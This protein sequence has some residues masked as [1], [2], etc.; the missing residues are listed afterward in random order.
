MTKKIITS[1]GLDLSLTGTGIVLLEGGDIKLQRLI[2]SKPGGDKPVNELIRIRTIVEEIEMI[3][4]EN[5]PTV[6]VIEGMAFMARNTTALVQLAALN[7]MTRSLL[8]DYKIPFVICAPTS[9][10]KFITGKGNS[11]KDV[12]LIETFKRYDKTILNDNEND[13]FGLAKIGE[14]LLSKDTNKLPIF[15]Q[16]VLK[17]ITKQL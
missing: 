2:K 8:Y 15:Q 11:K 14:M 7:Y 9:L 6:T 16:E 10:K 12:M 3:V 1:L 4:S 17:L 5:L 13:A